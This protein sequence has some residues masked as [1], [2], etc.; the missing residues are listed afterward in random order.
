MGSGIANL[1]KGY[2]RKFR[3]P[4]SLS[5]SISP[6]A[7]KMWLI[8]SGI[9]E[10]A[11]GTIAAI[12]VTPKVTG[13]V[14][15]PEIMIW[16]IAATELTGYYNLFS[17]SSSLKLPT[18]HPIFLESTDCIAWSSGDATDVLFIEVLEFDVS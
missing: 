4:Y 17:N 8:L 15:H 1:F 5:E 14:T 3:Y 18:W 9:V 11:T 12:F 2:I 7:N 10:F 6:P 13:T 16:E